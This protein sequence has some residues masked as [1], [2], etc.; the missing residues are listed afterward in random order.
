[1]ALDVLERSLDHFKLNESI[2]RIVIFRRRLRV[3]DHADTAN[4]VAK[5]NRDREHGAHKMLTDTLPLSV[6]IDG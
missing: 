3:D 2:T 4:F 5:F 6:S 1:M